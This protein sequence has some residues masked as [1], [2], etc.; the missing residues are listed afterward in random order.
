[1]AQF[2]WC[3]HFVRASS[4]FVVKLSGVETHSQGSILFDTGCDAIAPVRMRGHSDY[5][6]L[7]SHLV[8]LLL[9]SVFEMDGVFAWGIMKGMAFSLV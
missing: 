2:F 8:K 3:C 5:D 7:F 4:Q 1:M 6:S 9:E